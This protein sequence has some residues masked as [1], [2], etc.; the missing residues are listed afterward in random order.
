MSETVKAAPLPM[1]QQNGQHEQKRGSSGA[2]KG[3]VAGVFSGIAKLSGESFRPSTCS[4]K[5]ADRSCSWSSVRYDQSPITNVR[6]DSVQRTIGLPDANTT[7]R[8][9]FRT[10]QRRHSTTSWLD[11]HGQCNAGKSDNV[12]TGTQR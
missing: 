5:V 11:V 7:K 10:L 2:Y 9:I 12:P 1:A 6:D 4:V 3:F 8:G